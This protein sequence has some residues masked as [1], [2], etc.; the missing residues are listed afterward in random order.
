[1]GMFTL[2]SLS[3]AYFYSLF[4]FTLDKKF[5][6]RTFPPACQ[7]PPKPVN[8]GGDGAGVSTSTAENDGLGGQSEIEG[9]P[10]RA[11]GRQG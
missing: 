4:L 1:M 11:P 5:K 6:I 8:E 10:P 3:Y 7:S 9:S 2:P